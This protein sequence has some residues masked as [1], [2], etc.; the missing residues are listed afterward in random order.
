MRNIAKPVELTDIL[1]GNS[2]NEG[3]TVLDPFMGIGGCGVSA[4]KLGRKFIG[5]ELDEKYYNI[6][7]DRICEQCG[8]VI[9]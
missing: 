2:C 7:H 6:A 9:E 5:C 1:I 3:D 4:A 8:D